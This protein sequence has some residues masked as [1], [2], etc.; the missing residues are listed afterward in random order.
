[1]Y[2][3]YDPDIVEDFDDLD[4]ADQLKVLSNPFEKN[5]P[6]YEQAADTLVRLLSEENN[7]FQATYSG[8]EVFVSL[9]GEKII[10]INDL[11]EL[12]ANN[13]KHALYS[14]T[15]GYV[16]LHDNEEDDTE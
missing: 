13:N 11:D 4:T 6:H 12:A 16:N 8:H 1:M 10:S 15:E 5:E 7:D 9:N 14:C 2:D 3:D